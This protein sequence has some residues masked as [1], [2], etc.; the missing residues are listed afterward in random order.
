[1]LA[2]LGCMTTAGGFFLFFWYR[3]VVSLPRKR[4]PVYIHSRL[5]KWGVPLISA[6]VFAA[7]LYELLQINRW[8]APAILACSIVLSFL[9]VK[10]DRY[11]AEARII[12][13]HYRQVRAANPDMDEMEVLFLTARWRYPQWPHDRI[14]ELVAGK[15]VGNLIVL[16]LIN[17]NRINPISDWELYRSIKARVT[18]I[19]S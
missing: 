17:E 2:L 4:Q 14:V 15:D 3:T 1:M 18:R 5:F 12:R 10:F 6:L 7:G 19:V 8:L 13:D 11:S 16:M 9:T